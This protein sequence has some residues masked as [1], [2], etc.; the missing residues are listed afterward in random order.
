MIPQIINARIQ[1]SHYRYKDKFD[2]RTRLSADCKKDALHDNTGDTSVPSVQIVCCRR[3]SRVSTAE[4]GDEKMSTQIKPKGRNGPIYFSELFEREVSEYMKG[5]KRRV[6]TGCVWKF[7]TMT[8]PAGAGCPGLD[9]GLLRL[10]PA[11]TAGGRVRFIEFDLFRCA[12]RT[13]MRPVGS[14]PYQRLYETAKILE[15]HLRDWHRSSYP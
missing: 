2:I 6:P 15:T 4:Q 11:A 9:S 7:A 5:K 3:L 8:H 12:R 14:E 1:S 13:C 10:I